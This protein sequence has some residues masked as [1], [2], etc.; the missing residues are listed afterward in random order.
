MSFGF[1]PRPKVRLSKH[2]YH[3]E[4]KFTCVMGKMIPCFYEEVMPGD[5]WKF[6]GKALIRT[7][8][9]IAPIY[10]RVDIYWRFYYVPYRLLW[11][12]FTDFIT[13]FE[14]NTTGEPTVATYAL[15]SVISPA[16]TGWKTSSLADYLGLVTGVPDF[17][18]TSGAFPFRAYAKVI[19]DWHINQFTTELLPIS[20]AD[21]LDSTTNTELY[22]ANWEDDYFTS[23]S[24]QIQIGNPV[25][26]PLGVSAPVVGNGKSMTINT[27]TG[28]NAGLAGGD[29]FAGVLASAYNV[30]VGSGGQAVGVPNPIPMSGMGL[31][32]DPETSNVLADLT[33]ASALTVPDLRRATQLSLYQETL[34]YTG[35]RFVDWLF[36]MFGVRSSDARLQRSEF[37]G[38]TMSPLDI[39]SVVQTS[40]TTETD[41]PQGNLSGLAVSGTVFPSWKR[42]FEE[43]GCVIGLMC[44]MPRTG[45]QQ[46][47]RRMFNRTSKYD[48][49]LPMLQ[50]LGQ[51]PIQEQE[52]YAQSDSLTTEVNG[53]QVSNTTTFGFQ[54]PYEDFRYMPSTSHGDFKGTLQYWTLDRTFEQPPL[55][56][57]DFVQSQPSTRVFA[58]QDTKYDDCLVDV[59]YNITA[60]RPIARHGVPGYLDHPMIFGKGG[61]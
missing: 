19:N 54:W 18:N 29:G 22:S 9:L 59:L 52:I 1:Y 2:K 26:L 33:E 15:P 47:S 58:V 51:Q 24:T 20:T 21:G 46:G 17:T 5:I 11:E 61:L 57:A 27:S 55:L 32:T 42:R 49:P 8:P 13:G 7:Q 10:H 39:S 4:R 31:G 48:Y 14:Q 36:A 30:N 28:N 23:A 34:A 53:T 3:P 16:E 44:I 38:G 43:H 60:W 25:Y 56:N 6:G 35:Y 12:H 37:L 40:A 41:T 45:Y 50:H